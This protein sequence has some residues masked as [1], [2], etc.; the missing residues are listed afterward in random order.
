M[1]NVRLYGRRND[2]AAATQLTHKF[3][4]ILS[5]IC[6]ISVCDQCPDTFNYVHIIYVATIIYVKHG[7]LFELYAIR[8]K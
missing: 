8:T 7:F 5:V 4:S 3:R 1:T 6:V 2:D